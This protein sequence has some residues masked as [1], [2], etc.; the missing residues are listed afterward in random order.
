[1]ALDPEN[2][3][4]DL[5]PAATA[6]AASTYDAPGY[7]QGLHHRTGGL[8]AVAN[9]WVPEA[10]NYW[11][12]KNWAARLERFVKR[13][14]LEPETVFDVGAGT[15]YWVDWWLAHSARAVS[16]CDLSPLAVE[17]LT[18]RFGSSFIQLDLANDA[19]PGTFDLVSVMNVLLHIMDPAGFQRALTAVADA[20]RPGGHLL[21]MEP[22]LFGS[23]RHWDAQR[24][25]ATS[26]ARRTREY[27]DP[28]LAAGLRLVAVEAATALGSDPIE[29]G[30]RSHRYWE[31]VWR[32]NCGVSRKVP[33]LAP[34]VG[35][36]I[37]R[38]DPVC[39]RFGAAPS[40]KFLLMQRPEAGI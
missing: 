34:L 3:V 7:W 11:F 4:P 5:A 12:Y 26:R 13:Q 28:L 6:G 18:A 15:G 9:P 33:V 20:V 29:F 17:R 39:L 23:P 10:L 16:G 1:M 31:S 22:L 14:R 21:L 40:G 36:A 35:R 30:R 25:G 8:A 19:I 24:A 37:Y 32:L 38:L 27:V 2:P